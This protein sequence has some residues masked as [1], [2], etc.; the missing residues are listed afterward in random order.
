MPREEQ[1]GGLSGCQGCGPQDPCTPWAQQGGGVWGSEECADYGEELGQGRKERACLVL[2]AW[3]WVGCC[4][5]LLACSAAGTGATSLSSAVLAGFCLRVFMLAVS[6]FLAFSDF[7][8]LQL[9]THSITLF[10]FC[11]HR[12]LDTLDFF[13]SFVYVFMSLLISVLTPP[14][15]I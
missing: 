14:V 4:P 11:P 6:L 2:S 12:A 13:C 9:R 1:H 10:Q 15:Q 3:P 8:A 5:H 7:P